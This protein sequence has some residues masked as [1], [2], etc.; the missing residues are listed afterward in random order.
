MSTIGAIIGTLFPMLVMIMLGIAWLC[1]GHAVAIP[2]HPSALLPHLDNLN[3]LSFLIAVLFGL[4]GMEMSAV[5]AEEVKDPQSDYPRALRWSTLLILGSLVLSSL[6][7][8]IV[9]PQKDISL[10]SGVIDAFGLFFRA[11][12]LSWMI[13]IIVVCI[14]IGGLSGVSAWIIGPTKGLLIAAQEGCLPKGLQTVN[15]HGVPTRILL[16]QGAIF[17]VLSMAFLLFPSVNATY[18]FF[19]ALT[20]QLAMIVYLFMF[21]AGIRLR[22]LKPEVVRSYRV[23]YGN[24][25]MWIIA[26]AGFLTSFG[27]I[28]VGF[29]PPPDIVLGS[30]WRYEGLLSLGIILA[31]LAPLWMYARQGR[32]R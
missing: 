10:V 6:A 29:L 3:N 8:A 24:I 18:W 14:I 4:L 22:Y 12:H 30:L 17:T 5:H 7:I 25:G 20:A 15:R 9:I 11:F 13:P 2:W 16:I 26:G 32:E 28:L 31:L 19:S 27:A 1:S 21:A 23:P